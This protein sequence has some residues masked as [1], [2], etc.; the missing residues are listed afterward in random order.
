MQRRDGTSFVS[1]LDT[2]IDAERIDRRVQRIGDSYAYEVSPVSVSLSPMQCLASGMNWF[3]EL[4]SEDE[5]LVTS[6]R[7]PR[8]V[9]GIDMIR[10]VH[11]HV[12]K[13][14]SMALRGR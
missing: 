9:L 12:Q 3:L 10:M 13:M 14:N 6:R 4:V 5:G 11:S 7:D 8:L 1:T 2:S